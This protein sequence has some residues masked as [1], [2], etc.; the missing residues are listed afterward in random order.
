VFDRMNE[1]RGAPHLVWN[2][3]LADLA[4]GHSY[5]MAEA[6]YE[7][8]G[9]AGSPNAWLVNERAASA[10][11]VVVDGWLGE[12]ALYGDFD[13]WLGGDMRNAAN[14]WWGSAGHQAPIVD[15]NEAGVG[16]RF[17]EITTPFAYTHVYLTAVFLCP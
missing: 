3:C 17:E 8:H 13:D 15:C 2:D 5:D 16:V 6:G 10:G 9:S 1:L 4:R 12:N 7:G 11:L 14:M